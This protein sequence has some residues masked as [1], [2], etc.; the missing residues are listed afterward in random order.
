MSNEKLNAWANLLLDTGKKNNLINYRESKSNISILLPEFKD[1]FLNL[2]SNKVF[3]VFNPKSKI[4]EYDYD[5]SNA[6]LLNS[7]DYKE[8]YI[9]RIKKNNLLVYSESNKPLTNLKTMSRKAKTVME[10]NGINISYIALGFINWEEAS[11]NY[12]APFMLIPIIIE[13]DSPLKPVKI[14][15]IDDELIINPTFS[16]KLVTEHNITIPEYDDE[17]DILDYILLVNKTLLPLGWYVSLESAVGLFSFQKINM[18]KDLLDNQ[19]VILSNNC[20]KLLLDEPG[21]KKNLLHDIKEFEMQSLNNIVDADSSQRMAI[22][23]AKNNDS[24]VLEGPP[25]TGK[26]Q[27]ITNIIA[28]SIANSK[29]VL[30][31]SEKLAALNVVYNKLKD[32]GLEDYLLELHSNKAN[33]KDIIN[34][35][36]TTYKKAKIDLNEKLQ[37]DIDIKDENEMI[38]DNYFH[39][40][41]QKN[42]VIDKTLFELISLLSSKEEGIDLDYSIKKIEEKGSDYLTLATKLIKRYISYVPSIG[43]DYHNNPWYGFI[44]NDSSIDSIRTIKDNFNDVIDLYKSYIDIKDKYKNELDIN[45]SNYNDL[46]GYKFILSK[47]I[48]KEFINPKLLIL[49]NAKKI[50]DN[51]D[52]LIDLSKELCE[53]EELINNKY[54]KNFYN[55]NVNYK[56]VLIEDFDSKFKR[57]FSKKYKIIRNEIKLCN[58]SLKKDTYENLINDLNILERYNLLLTEYNEICKGYDEILQDKYNS[59]HTNYSK[60]NEE[61]EEIIPALADDLGK[62]TDISLDEYRNIKFKEFVKFD[63]KEELIDNVSQSFNSKLFDLKNIEFDKAIDKLNNCLENIK[64]C[65]NYIEFN[66]LLN[67]L[68]ANE[69]K[70]YIDF[71]I[72]NNIDINE[73]LLAYEKLFYKL[74]VDKIIHKEPALIELNRI[75]HDEVLETFKDKDKLSL[76][77]NRSKI[78]S[79][80]SGLKSESNLISNDTEESILLREANK[81]KKQKGIR[82][83]L[84]EIENLAKSIKPVFLMS[85][86]SVS[87]YL[88]PN[89]KF[90][91]VIFDEASQIFPEDAIGA[92]YRGKQLIVVGDTKQMPPSN[93]FTS[94]LETNDEDFDDENLNDYES[95]L[96]L[97]Q[98]I[99]PQLRLKWHY[100]SKFEDLI[101][102]SNNNFYDNEL[103]TFPSALKSKDGVGIDYHYT[104]GTYDRKTRTNLAEANYV[105]ELVFE[106]I[107]KYP[108]RSIG[109]IAFS[110][111]QQVLIER[112]INKRRQIDKTFES[113]FE[114]DTKEPFFVKNLETVQGDER[115]TIIFSIAYGYDSS[116]KLLL[117]FGPLNKAGGERRLNVLITRAKYNLIVVS[118]MH[119]SDI[120]LSHVSSKGAK[121]LHDYLEYAENKNIKTPE[122]PFDDSTYLLDEVYN[123]LIENGYTIEKFVGNSS[124]KIDLAL[125]NPVLNDYIMAIEL[126][127]ISYKKTKT[128]RDR[129]RLREEILKSMGWKYYRIWSCDWY[130]NKELEKA[131]LLDACKKAFLNK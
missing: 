97:C 92:I 17:M 37:K 58:K 84:S 25:G 76:V 100:R 123:F 16:Y 82:N 32:C 111:S 65:D 105:C 96:D 47:L 7:D 24:F 15:V 67:E 128:V 4:D 93:F 9:N 63:L 18:Y 107:R 38:L 98:T 87:T 34:E 23:M 57:L 81:K 48:D 61:L 52:R 8:K 26:S 122:V 112:L 104:E 20:V 108:H 10:E 120:D 130:R 99:L 22:L 102:F 110:I 1:L 88:N 35:L 69:L 73:I 80:A 124:M 117:N 49:S 72:K 66:K 114:S 129:D 53:L 116:H 39:L 11:K 12:K 78:R 43:N 68:E 27:T 60:L 14:L 95:I 74:W 33:K 5:T 45:I 126:D 83:L 56:K 109:V 115:D 71:T 70:D 125:V 119:Y 89:F 19:D 64:S 44:S 118:S 29:S 31:V 62:L 30:F 50:E 94:S 36:A 131:R 21:A 86:L 13:S 59:Y 79:L 77:I 42:D 40:I 54:D 85:P 3:E 113:Y 91:L 90:D 127:G 46:K 75:K 6:E 101:S 41:H 55:I 28:E 121:L 2:R 103:I 51:I 106:Q